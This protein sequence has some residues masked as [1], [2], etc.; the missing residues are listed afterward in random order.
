MNN[1]ELFKTKFENFFKMIVA[2]G[3]TNIKLVKIKDTPGKSQGKIQYNG[4][5]IKLNFGGDCNIL[6]KLEI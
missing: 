3:S 2:G 5:E 6:F 4:V 1:F